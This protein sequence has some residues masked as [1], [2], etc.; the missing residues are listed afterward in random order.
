MESVELSDTDLDYILQHMFV[1][2]TNDPLNTAGDATLSVRL[3]I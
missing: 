1:D 3:A 2:V